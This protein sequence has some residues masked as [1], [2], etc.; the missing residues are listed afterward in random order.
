MK[1]KVIAAPD[2][3]AW[4]VK[5]P[6]VER[7]TMAANLKEVNAMASDLIEIM[8]G[9]QHPELDVHIEL[10]KDVQ[11]RLDAVRELRM[12]AGELEERAAREQSHAVRELHEAGIT[13]RDIGITLGISYQRAHQLAN[14]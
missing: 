5:V 1:Y 6:Q 9:E 7:V 13:Y 14:T 8:T 3:N 12:Q 10:P 4:E 11:S 2:E